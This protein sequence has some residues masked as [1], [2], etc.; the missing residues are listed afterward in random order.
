[1][2]DG[3]IIELIKNGDESGLHILVEKYEK[4][5]VY[6]I[7]GVLGERSRDVEECVN[8]T[9]L[10]FW[11]HAAEYDLERASIV[12]YLKVIARNT[13]LNRLRDVKRHEDRRMQGDIS[14]VAETCEDARQ[15]IESD[16]LR[17]EH[18]A[19]LNTVIGA[20]PEKERE[21]MIRKYYYLQSSKVIAKA[22]GMTVNAVDSKLSR[23]RGKMREEFS[24]IE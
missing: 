2:S 6:L 24:E 4:L 1:M 14:E 22:M 3:E 18:M 9:W 13:A 23:L 17:K 5:L 11:K 19:R 15:N 16:I 7:T 10:K 8:D 21:L 12:T 20:M